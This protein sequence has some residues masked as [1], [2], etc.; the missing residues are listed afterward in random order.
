MPIVK[1]NFAGLT[2]RLTNLIFENL[3]SVDI[4][5]KNWKCKDTLEKFTLSSPKN[6]STE[7][8]E[9]LATSFANFTVLKSLTFDSM[10]SIHGLDRESA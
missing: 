10:S 1:K 7:K 5:K 8:L 6:V 2:C 3:K 4:A 9:A